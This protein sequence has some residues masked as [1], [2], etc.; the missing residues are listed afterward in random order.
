MSATGPGLRE[1]KNEQTRR[2]ITSAALELA[3]EV[4]FEHATVA[5]IAERANVSPRTVHAWFPSKEDIVVG[6]S[7]VRIDQLAA[8]LQTGG[9]EDTIERIVRWLAT[10]DAARTEPDELTRLRHR[11]VLA[12]PQLRAH[13]RGRLAAVEKLIASAI[14]KETGLSSDALAPRSLAAAIATMLLAMQER[15]ADSRDE[16]EADIDIALKMLRAALDDLRGQR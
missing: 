16:D 1:R 15:F 13:Q 2:A 12:D 8:A 5:H 11:V 10:V 9:E 6:T 4:G 7:D 3:S 14:A